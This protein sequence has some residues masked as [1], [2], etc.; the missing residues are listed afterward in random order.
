[1]KRI[2][3]LLALLLVAAFAAPATAYPDKTG[4]CHRTASDS[5]PYVLIFP[6]ANSHDA[7]LGETK[8][9]HPAIESQMKANQHKPK[10][11]RQDY[12]ASERE[13]KQGYCGDKPPK[14]PVFDPEVEWMVCGDPRLLIEFT[15]DG[16]KPV[17]F[18]H[19]FRSATTGAWTIKYTWVAPG[20]TK[21]FVRWVK[22]RSYTRV[23]ATGYGN[24][25]VLLS[26]N[27][28]RATQWGAGSCPAN[29]RDAQNGW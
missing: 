12:V 2:A 20:E 19:G 17:R 13:L 8:A 7:H 10:H 24:K 29:L 23:V 16:D 27:L 11:G 26:R 25:E 5:N 4:I 22:G 1:M 6:D 15:N 18:K 14:D 9:D 3:P 21:Q 28:P